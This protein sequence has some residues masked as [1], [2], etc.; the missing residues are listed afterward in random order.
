MIR[1]VIFDVD[2]TLVDS[3][4]Y[5]AES[6]QRAFREFRKEVPFEKIR[7]QIGKGSD[8]FLPE[9]WSEEDL[10]KIG[11]PLEE[12]RADLFKKEYLP[13]VKGFPKVREL[14]LHLQA[15]GQKFALA[16]SAKG[17]ELQSY[18]IA[19][20][21]DD[22]IDRETSSDDAESSKPDP[23]IFEAALAKLGH[24]PLEETLVVGDTPWDIEAAKKAGLRTIAVRCGGFKEEH[25][26]GAIAIFDD[27]A[28]LLAHYSSSP[29][30]A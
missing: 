24:P 23:D 10:K 6:W 8:Q 30:A 20:G 26:R 27:P 29:L 11:K 3:V 21:I 19:A 22:L 2:G 5:H 25:L 28:D 13:R 15:C 17:D 14:F 1:A 16:S 4:D 18:K 9:F 12:F 7:F